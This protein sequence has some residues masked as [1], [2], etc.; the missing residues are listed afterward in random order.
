LLFLQPEYLSES[1][2]FLLA[3]LLLLGLDI[4]LFRYLG[5]TI[6]IANIIGLVL[7][8]IFGITSI[9]L[10]AQGNTSFLVLFTARTRSYIKLSCL[11]NHFI[12]GEIILVNRGF[13]W[14]NKKGR[15]LLFSDNISYVILK[16]KDYTRTEGG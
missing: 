11:T 5:H 1:F 13:F 4:L 15:K 3:E 2:G 8:N 12:K 16:H 9:F 14:H 6:D 7:P 10:I